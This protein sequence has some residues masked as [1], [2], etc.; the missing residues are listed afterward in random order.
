MENEK[1]TPQTNENPDLT[2]YQD[3]TDMPASPDNDPDNETDEFD[4]FLAP[5]PRP[6]CFFD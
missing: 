3:L 4:G 2:I 1:I 6:E 5:Y